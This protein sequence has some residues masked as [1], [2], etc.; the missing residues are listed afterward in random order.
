MT[1]GHKNINKCTCMVGDNRGVCISVLGKSPQGPW[2]YFFYFRFMGTFTGPDP[3]RAALQ[4]KCDTLWIYGA[5]QLDNFVCCAPP[6]PL[7]APRSGLSSVTAQHMW[8]CWQSGH[9]H[10]ILR[11]YSGGKKCATLTTKRFWVNCFPDLL[12]KKFCV[13]RN[14]WMNGSSTEYVCLGPTRQT[15]WFWCASCLFLHV[16]KTKTYFK[17]ESDSWLIQSSALSQKLSNNSE[18]LPHLAKGQ[19]HEQPR[20]SAVLNKRVQRTNWNFSEQVAKKKKKKCAWMRQ[21]RLRRNTTVIT[22]V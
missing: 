11:S 15:L 20:L 17:R 9:W 21:L 14:K 3:C 6:P 7:T 5:T 22:R 10:K 8:A 13:T 4:R 1:S 2:A 19:L 18:F 12:P 16:L